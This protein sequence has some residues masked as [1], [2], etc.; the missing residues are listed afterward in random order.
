MIFGILL[1]GLDNKLSFGYIPLS[2]EWQRGCT[3]V[4][5]DSGVFC[6]SA[7]VLVLNFTFC[8]LYSSTL[9]KSVITFA[10][11][12]VLAVM[13]GYCLYVGNFDTVSTGLTG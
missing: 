7:Y 13:F 4:P 2:R 3:P 10:D 1:I 9:L 6:S 12:Q 5:V 8:K 11:D